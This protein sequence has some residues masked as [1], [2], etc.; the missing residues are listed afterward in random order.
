MLEVPSSSMIPNKVMGEK[1]CLFTRHNKSTTAYQISRDSLA[2][3]IIQSLLHNH[4]H[5]IHHT[6][7]ILLTKFTT[8]QTL[9]CPKIR[10]VC[11]CSNST[12]H[13]ATG[14]FVRFLTSKSTT[15][16]VKKMPINW[17]TLKLRVWNT[18]Q[19]FVYLCGSARARRSFGWE[20]DV[21]PW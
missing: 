11:A 14:G 8:G 9:Q 4:Y 17:F 16:V 20:R 18:N 7:T 2:Q 1:R 10:N 6:A 3:C 5:Y 13:V 21:N 19:L 15:N 12:N